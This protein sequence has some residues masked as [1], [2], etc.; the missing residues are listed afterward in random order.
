MTTR[1]KRARPEPSGVKDDLRKR[2]GDVKKRAGDS[3]GR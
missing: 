3:V 2:A 1:L